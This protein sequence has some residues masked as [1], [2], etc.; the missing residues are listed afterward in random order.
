M[1]V[2]GLRNALELYAILK[3]YMVADE[4]AALLDSI[5][6]KINNEEFRRCVFLMTGEEIREGETGISEFIEGMRV[7]QIVTMQSLMEKTGIYG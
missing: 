3:P 2:I 4:P 5:F 7:N 1:Q 6:T